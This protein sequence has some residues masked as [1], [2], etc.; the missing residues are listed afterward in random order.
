VFVL[1]YVV[2]GYD[3][4]EDDAARRLYATLLNPP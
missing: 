3:D 2:L 4:I 1:G